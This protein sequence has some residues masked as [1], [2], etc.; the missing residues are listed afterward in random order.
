MT[1]ARSPLQ[2][3]LSEYDGQSV[4][5]LGE[6]E[7]EYSGQADYLDAVIALVDHA[8]ANICGGATWLI[9]SALEAGRQLSEPQ[10][11][12]FIR[13]V[14]MANGWA[15]QL[16]VCQS[17]QF[18]QVS[19][20]HAPALRD[21]LKPLLASSRPFV[22]AWSVDALE[23]LACQHPEFALEAKAALDAAEADPA[24]SVRA[25][26]RQIRKRLV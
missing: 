11:K 8:D 20:D 16:H 7:A 15:A 3:R 19:A 13:R 24:A 22:R 2:L 9:K 17:I 6:I 10:R 5:I 18:L 26:A 12:E 21:W 23:H 14:P 25:R 1:E 4:T